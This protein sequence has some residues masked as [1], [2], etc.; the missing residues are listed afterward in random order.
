MYAIHCACHA[1]P[2]AAMP[3][4]PASTK[5]ARTDL[6]KTPGTRTM[7]D[8]LGV[9]LGTRIIS[10]I[11]LHTVCDYIFT[12]L[13]GSLGGDLLFPQQPLQLQLLSIH[14]ELQCFR[15]RCEKRKTYCNLVMFCLW[16]FCKLHLHVV[17]NSTVLA[18]TLIL[19]AHPR[20]GWEVF[21]WTG[22]NPFRPASMFS[23]SNYL[24]SVYRMLR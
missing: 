15:F 13:V 24:E 12:Y 1:R 3:H 19:L 9:G 17:S 20:E 14:V 21:R 18:T 11:V 6:T 23:G 2:T 5:N 10:R 16:P 8:L 22:G 7:N 4:H